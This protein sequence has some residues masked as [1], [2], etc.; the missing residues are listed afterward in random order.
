MKFV[1]KE[2]SIEGN[3]KEMLEK[4]IREGKTVGLWLDKYGEPVTVTLVPRSDHDDDVIRFHEEMS[5]PSW[6]ICIAVRGRLLDNDGHPMLIGD[7]PKAI[8]AAERERTR[9]YTE[10]EKEFGPS[11]WPR[12]A[13]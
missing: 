13:A 2:T 12:S 5:V 1:S 10:R 11:A 3:P 8:R 7:L 9:F 6:P 4:A